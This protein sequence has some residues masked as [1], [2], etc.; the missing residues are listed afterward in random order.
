MFKKISTKVVGY[1]ALMTTVTT[2]SMPTV[3]AEAYAYNGPQSCEPD[4]CYEQP[5]CCDDGWSNAWVV[6][7][8]G[9]LGAAAGAGVAYAVSNDKHGSKG[10]P[11][12]PGATGVNG[13][14]GTNGTTGATGTGFNIVPDGV[15]TILFQFPFSY[16]VT[17]INGP[18]PISIIFYVVLPDLTIL[19]SRF[20]TS[21]L[22]SGPNT[23]NVPFPD[24]IITVSAMS[25][26]YIAGV[27]IVPL[28]SSTTISVDIPLA[29]VEV[30]PS[31][32]LVSRTTIE[33]LTAPST[34]V[35]TAFEPTSIFSYYPFNLTP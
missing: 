22:A 17:L 9:L 25:G 32:P 11:G 15:N 30:V 10:D 3:S 8:S 35:G 29:T 1:L 26:D 21:S 23:I 5:E 16:N 18:S 31:N 27:R 20:T 19:T 2:F 28:N 33:L 7:G 14:S 34:E 13:T 24:F 6:I 4:C 12:T